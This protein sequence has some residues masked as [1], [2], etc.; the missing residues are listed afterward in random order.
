MLIDS[1]WLTH[2][3]E[4]FLDAEAGLFTLS[5]HRHEVA[6][7]AMLSSSSETVRLL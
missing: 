4:L 3:T 2:N 5:N 1:V 6:A 7:P